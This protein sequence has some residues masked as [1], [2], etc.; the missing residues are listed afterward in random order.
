M[1][2][3][4]TQPLTG[5][6]ILLDSITA[7]S[8]TP[9]TTYPLQR[10][11]ASFSGASATQLIVSVN[12]ITQAPNNAY[13]IDSNNNIVFTENLSSSDTID[14]IL[15]L[16]EVGDSVVP[17]DG[18]VTSAKLSSTLGRGTA[19]I[20]VN[21]NSLTTDQT[22]ASGENAGVF[23]PFSIPSSVTLTVNGT[24]TVV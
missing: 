15:A 3:I 1:P 11:G 6:F 5:E 9:P 2:Y 23:G 18:S 20:R 13:S 8:T 14:Y 17:T 7:G 10:G 16:G 21:T 22:I 24:F 12:G 4:G 19:P